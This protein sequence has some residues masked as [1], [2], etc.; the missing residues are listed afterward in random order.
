MKQKP[1]KAWIAKI[2]FESNIIHITV[3]VKN[4][5]KVIYSE[6]RRVKK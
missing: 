5:R 3:P 6:I 2:L 4:G 1:I